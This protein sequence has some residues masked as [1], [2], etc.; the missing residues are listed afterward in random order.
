MSLR[1]IWRVKLIIL[2]G[3]YVNAGIWTCVE[4][5][6]GIV[7]ACVPSLRPLV[8]VCFE[9]TARRWQNLDR[10]RHRRAFDCHQDDNWSEEHLEGFD[11]RSGYDV[12]I[13]SDNSGTTPMQH[14]R[15]GM[16]CSRDIQVKT[17]VLLTSTRGIEYKDHL[18]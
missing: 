10:A 2:A 18:F 6:M 7:S 9:K 11:L 1:I 4:P 8:Q 13:Q 12:H 16:D 14:T 17:E 15:C 5:T 3:D